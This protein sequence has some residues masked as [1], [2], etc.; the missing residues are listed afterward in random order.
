MVYYNQVKER[1]IQEEA[2]MSEL[3]IQK[4]QQEK[5]I[6]QVNARI[7]RKRWNGYGY[8]GFVTYQ[9]AQY[10]VYSLNGESWFLDLF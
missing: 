4:D 2:K 10:G 5:A 7:T 8:S 3:F 9:G 6:E 1:D